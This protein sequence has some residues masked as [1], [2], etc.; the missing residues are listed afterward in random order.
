LDILHKYEINRGK[1]AGSLQADPA[2]YLVCFTSVGKKVTQ[3]FINPGDLL[4]FKIISL[5][6]I[7]NISL[8]RKVLPNENA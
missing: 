5:L 1:Y 4:F 6:V 8:L 3:P 2:V 7:S